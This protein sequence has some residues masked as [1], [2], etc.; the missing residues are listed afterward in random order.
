VIE[1]QGLGVVARE[2][3]HVHVQMSAVDVQGKIKRN[4]KNLL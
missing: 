4:V 3:N 1:V 2:K